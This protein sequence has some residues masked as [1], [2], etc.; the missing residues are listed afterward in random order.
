MRK[1]N[2]RTLNVVR[3]SIKKILPFINLQ[4]TLLVIYTTKLLKKIIQ[5]VQKNMALLNSTFFLI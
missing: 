5:T 2:P 4:N 1:N 3:V